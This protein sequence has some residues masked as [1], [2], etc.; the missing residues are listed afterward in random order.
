MMTESTITA[1]DLKRNQYLLLGYFLYTTFYGVLRKWVFF[2]NPAVGNVLFTFQLLMPFLLFFFMKREKSAFS[3]PLL[4]PYTLLLV[5]FALNPMNHTLFHGIFGFLQHFGFWLVML[6]YVNER[7]LFPVEKLIPAFLVIGFGE[8]FFS[9]IQ[10]SLPSTHIINSYIN[11]D[12]VDGFIND[13]GVRVIGT[14][15]YIAGFGSFLFFLSMMIWALV[16]EGRRPT[17]VLLFLAVFTI[18]SSLMNGSRSI[19]FPVLIFLFFG[20]VASS[21]F[22]QK[23]K[24]LAIIATLIVLGLIYNID[25][26]IALA[27]KAFNSFAERVETGEKTGEHS[28]RTLS[29][30]KEVT[31]F[32]G[33]Y[34]LLGIGL[35]ATYQGATNTWGRSPELVEY[36]YCENEPARIVLEGGF[37]LF[38]VR[39]ALF[40]YLVFKLNIPFIFS[41]FIMM[42][43][44][45]YSL[46]VFN[47][48]HTTFVFFGIILLD[49]IYY[50][51]KNPEKEE[52]LL[53]EST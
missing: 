39:L 15:S 22:L 53:L 38:F 27:E 37:L 20:F 13:G 19:M 18:V 32:R 33:K 28:E 16:V 36:G 35:G 4:V 50:L 21:S 25:K 29:T 1:A 7:D 49:K 44:L 52:D 30:F 5:A 34:P 17:I 6:T 41:S 3:Y 42:Y 9:F 10:F 24:S 43:V 45:F 2:G 47:T 48:H 14:F 8:V 12:A 26:Q 31:E 46:F 51:K 40:G 23:A 11:A